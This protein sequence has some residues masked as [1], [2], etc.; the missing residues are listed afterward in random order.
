MAKLL[1]AIL[2][3]PTGKRVDQR[4]LGDHD[5][6]IYLIHVYELVAADGSVIEM[7]L[8]TSPQGLSHDLMINWS[9]NETAPA[10]QIQRRLIKKTANPEEFNRCFR[11]MEMA[12]TDKSAKLLIRQ[13]KFDI[14]AIAGEPET[15][16]PFVIE[17]GKPWRLSIEGSK[18]TAA[19][20]GIGADGVCVRSSA[21]SPAGA[22][23][24]RKFP[25]RVFVDMG[26][27]LSPSEHSQLM[28]DDVDGFR[29]GALS[30]LD[31]QGISAGALRFGGK[32]P[33]MFRMMNLGISSAAAMDNAVNCWRE[34]VAFECAHGRLCFD[35]GAERSAIIDGKTIKI[36]PAT[37]WSSGF[38]SWH[39][40]ILPEVVAS[41]CPSVFRLAIKQGVAEK[42]RQ[43][44]LKFDHM[45]QY[46]LNM[47][48]LVRSL[49]TQVESEVLNETMGK[50]A[51]SKRESL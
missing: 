17:P 4:L 30:R 1:K 3:D 28:A 51:V 19:V 14:H 13:F 38:C 35:N 39:S 23:L 49:W 18:K 25:G 9:S 21:F 37:V 26:P 20:V 24:A 29:E 33:G 10:E 12:K 27:T 5:A 41:T 11:S 7:V 22:E 48:D 50:G 47:G 36:D 44:L 40:S 6:G 43:A 8:P 2:T 32:L 46:G 42:A 34:I 45:D 15:K 16:G 31:A